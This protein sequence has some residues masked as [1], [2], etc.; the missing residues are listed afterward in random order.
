[1]ALMVSDIS[2]L[3]PLTGYY[4]I[5]ACLTVGSLIG[6]IF[7]PDRLHLKFRKLGKMFKIIGKLKIFSASLQH[8][9]SKGII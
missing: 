4:G 3:P 7:T 9:K 5:N 8:A 1:M 6:S 2:P